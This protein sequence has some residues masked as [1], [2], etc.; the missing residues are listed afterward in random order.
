[1]VLV[2]KKSGAIR[3][4]I[5]YRLLNAVTVKDSFPLPRI[6]KSLEA[7]GGAKHFSSMDLSHGYFQIAMDP[8]SVQQT[9]LRVPWGLFEFLRMPHSNVSWK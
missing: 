5:D 3:L 9:A 8:S 6:E 1:M 7:M 4:C 2:K